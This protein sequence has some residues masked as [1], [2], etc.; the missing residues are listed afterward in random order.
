MVIFDIL[1][2]GYVPRNEPPS[3]Y[4][5]RSPS[6]HHMLMGAA[7]ADKLADHHHELVDVLTF[8]PT[9]LIKPY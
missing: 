9:I 7:R 8:E 2:G 4:L 5:P 6:E 3:F 1:G